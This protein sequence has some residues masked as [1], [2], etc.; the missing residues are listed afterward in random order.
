M[1][2]EQLN[3]QTLIR[4]RIL[5][6][7]DHDQKV[8][9]EKQEIFCYS[10]EQL[11]DLYPDGG[12]TIVGETTHKNKKEIKSKLL[13]K[14]DEEL[15]VSEFKS[16]SRI[17]Y[18][19]AGYVKVGQDEYIAL[20]KSRLPFLILL[21]GSIAIL[22]VVAALLISLITTPAPGPVVIDPDH[23]VPSDDPNSELMEDDDTVK[24]DVE[25]GGGSLSMIYTLEAK[26]SLSTRQIDIYFKNP[27]ASTHDVSI[28]LYITSGENEIAIAQSGLL[29]AGH[30]LSKLTL[31][32]GAA[33]LREGVYTGKYLLSIFD[34]L[35]GERALVQPEITGVNL[36]VLP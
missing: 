27:N 7:T 3:E 16:H 14:K 21:F 4:Y 18:R 10:K 5:P 6:T 29:K 36:T 2:N 31:S 25:E 12:Y 15:D 20:L 8:K 1:T 9:I 17:L 35:T 11:D 33:V 23:P 28:I 26:L 24:P 19:V 30:S 22:A 13:L 32:E 34:P